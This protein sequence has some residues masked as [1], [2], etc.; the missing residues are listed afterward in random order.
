MSSP[1]TV[2]ARNRTFAAR[3][4]PVVEDWSFASLKPSQTLWGPH[5]YHR[6]P[7]KF[8]PQLARRI[9]ENY[10]T[11]DSLV[12]D[13]FLGSATTG[14]EAIR[15]GRAFWGA[16]IN[17]VALL[18]SQAKCI[19]LD[20]QK[21][22]NSWKRL[23]GQLDLLP[24]IGRRLLTEAERTSIRSINIARASS[25]ERLAYWFP[26]DHR[27]VLEQ[28]LRLI[29]RLKNPS[30]RTFFLCAFSNMLRGCSI[31]L[32]GS[33]KPQKDLDK[34][35]SDPVESFR[36][37]VRDMIRRNNAY[38]ADLIH[39]NINPDIV[40][41]WCAIEFQDARRLHIRDGQLDLI[42]TS[43]PYATCYQYLDIHQL[44]QLWFEK[45]RIIEPDDMRQAC[46]G[47]KAVSMRERHADDTST[48]S[49]A[50]DAALS[51]LARLC[52]GT[53]EYAVDREMRALRYYFQDMQSAIKEMARVLARG[54]YLVLIVGDS[55]KRGINIPTS[56]ALSE[57]AAVSGLTL[58][59]KIVRQ[60]PARVLV[61]TR[62]K[63]TGRFSSAEQSDTQV[64]PEE[65]IL[66]FKRS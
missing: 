6:Y 42:V 54:K 26:A 13:P 8:I 48:G 30:L 41:S 20:A 66:I 56:A 50:A 34:T 24:R 15:A 60:V 64:Y 19:P 17:P 2:P 28:Q 27:T 31:W 63:K 4:L 40:S 10:S 37:Q 62:D 52:K 16:D 44:T 11:P 25:E 36:R 3:V 46:I 29:T 53:A 45:H 7:A 43:P 58:E 65:D 35:L 55:Y 39:S 51:K 14:I 38:S 32:S 49:K 5:G 47:G 22:S 9:I 61:S 59:R 23:E 33:T 1:S 18:I 12:G 21:L 57:M